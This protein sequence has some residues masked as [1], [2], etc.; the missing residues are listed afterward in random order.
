MANLLA[1]GAGL[2]L[3][4]AVLVERHERSVN[5]AAPAA[6]GPSP[7]GLQPPLQ[8]QPFPTWEV[9]GP[10][11][12]AVV[13]TAQR[14]LFGFG[15]DVTPDGILGT[16]TYTALQDF[17]RAHGQPATT[18]LRDALIALDAAYR[19]GRAGSP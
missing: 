8:P 6:P 1:W 5:A 2:G 15:Y 4:T 9:T 12:A 11:P 18:P 17:L 10:P 7:A 3:L 13:K 19:Q 14:Q 16:D